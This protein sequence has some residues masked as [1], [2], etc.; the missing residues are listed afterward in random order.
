MSGMIDTP[1][2]NNRQVVESWRLG[3][4]ARSHNGAL[5]CDGKYLMSYHMIIGARLS[6]GVCIVRNSTAAGGEYVSQTTSTHVGLAKQVASTVMH[7]RV[8]DA[9]PELESAAIPF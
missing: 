2:M 6:E 1:R 7:P 4:R 3:R 5:T 9:T 8:W